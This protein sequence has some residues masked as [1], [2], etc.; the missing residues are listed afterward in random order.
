MEVVE[1]ED[2]SEALER[3]RP[4]LTA[5]P[6]EHNL[7]LTIIDQSIEFS[8]GG[9]FWLVVDD[10]EVVGFALESPPG[11]GAVL[12]SM[13]TS[14]CKLLAESATTHLSRVVGEAGAAARVRRPVDRVP[15]DLGHQDRGTASLRAHRLDAGRA[16][17]RISTPGRRR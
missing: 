3:A 7:L 12:A 15:F 2:A 10:S 6:V 13:P 8:L 9:T 1:L 14:A 11:M 5:R 17:A 4:F 16:R